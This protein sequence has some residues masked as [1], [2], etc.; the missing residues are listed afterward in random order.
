MPPAGV[1]LRHDGMDGLSVLA[2]ARPRFAAA[3]RNELQAW[4]DAAS[5]GQAVGANAWDGYAAAAVADACLRAA[6]TG[7]T[8]PVELA[9]KPALYADQQEPS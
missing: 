5:V 1:T 8:T 7:T 2:D 4:A 9:A 6:K 3:F